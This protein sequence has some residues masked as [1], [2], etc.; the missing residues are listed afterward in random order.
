MLSGSSPGRCHSQSLLVH[1]FPGPIPR[2]SLGTTTS[3]PIPRDQYLPRTNTRITARTSVGTSVVVRCR[4]QVSGVRCQVSG[5]RCRGRGR[6]SGP[7]PPYQ[8]PM[9]ATNADRSNYCIAT[10]TPIA[11]VVRFHM[12]PMVAA[13][14]R[15]VY[16]WAMV[17]LAPLTSLGAPLLLDAAPLR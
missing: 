11:R 1:Q 15:P 3:G 4:C 13:V 7:I 10:G 14:A 17:P 2:T 8:S 5:V 16:R 9:A 12:P 6:V